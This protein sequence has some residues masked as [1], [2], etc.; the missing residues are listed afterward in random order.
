MPVDSI[1]W[2]NTLSGIENAIEISRGWSSEGK[3]EPELIFMHVLYTK[4]RIPI[5]ERKKLFEMKKKKVEEEFKTIKK[6]CMEKGLSN[7]RTVIREGKPA[8][9]IVRTAQDEDVGLIVMGSGKLHDRSARGRI[10]K[11]VYGSTTEEV[12][13]EAPCSI[14]VAR[15]IPVR[16][17]RSS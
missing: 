16:L 14:L 9:E 2:D 3:G 1:K 11:F 15:P 8:K 4:P 12:I 17:K 5:S 10:H 6:M 13:H 7:I